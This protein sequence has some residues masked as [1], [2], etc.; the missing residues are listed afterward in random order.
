MKIVSSLT[1][2]IFAVVFAG[3]AL[4]G[5]NAETP[6][7][8]PGDKMQQ[9]KPGMLRTPSPSPWVSVKLTS[10]WLQDAHGKQTY[11]NGSGPL[12]GKQFC[13]VSLWY[14]ATVKSTTPA[15][16]V[17][18]VLS[19]G[20]SVA[21]ALQ[22][23]GAPVSGIYTFITGGSVDITNKSDPDAH[24]PAQIGLLKTLQ[25][26]VQVLAPTFLDKSSVTSSQSVT[27]SG[28]Q[29]ANITCSLDGCQLGK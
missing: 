26:H 28:A 25:G 10:A 13:P 29:C 11:W 8:A 19:D 27:V 18:F 2:L 5:P 1:T 4:A 15:P 3:A 9:L 23:T 21:A 12:S 14:R 7:K 20:T 22:S 16:S 6:T 17:A 24:A